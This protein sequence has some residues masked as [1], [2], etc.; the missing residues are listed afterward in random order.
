MSQSK[1]PESRA[2]LS[3]I[4]LS[5]LEGEPQIFRDPVTHKWVKARYKAERQELVA[6]YAEWEIIGQPEYRR[7]SGVGFNPS[8]TQ[9]VRQLRKNFA[10]YLALTPLLKTPMNRLVVRITLR[11]HVPLRAG[12]ENPNLLR[13]QSAP[14][15]ACDRNDDLECSLRENA[16]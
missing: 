9:L 1:G 12:V 6:R 10:Q 5:Q 4:A 2:R 15:L 13:A 8:V 3:R 7:A 11:K 16:P 14:E